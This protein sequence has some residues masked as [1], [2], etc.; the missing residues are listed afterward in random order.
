VTSGPSHR[1]PGENDTEMKRYVLEN[2]STAFPENVLAEQ[3]NYTI[4]FQKRKSETGEDCE[5]CALLPS[6]PSDAKDS[7]TA[8]SFQVLDDGKL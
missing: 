1:A 6:T 2:D 3:K 5:A 8:L 7:T 4:R